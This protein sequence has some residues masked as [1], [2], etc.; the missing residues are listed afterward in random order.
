M[1]SKLRALL[2][3]SVLS[4]ASCRGW[5]LEDRTGCPRLLYFDIQN[6]GS[7]EAGT[8]V[9]VHAFPHQTGEPVREVSTTVRDIQ[10]HIFGVEVRSAQ[11]VEGY[12]LLGG[13]SL[14]QGADGYRLPAGKSYAPLFRFAYLT[15]VPEEYGVL[16][17]ELLKEYAGVRL[18]FVGERGPLA[19]TVRANTCGLR[20]DTGEPLQ[21]PF[22]CRLS[23]DDDGFYHF[24]LPRL[25][26]NRLTLEITGQNGLPETLDLFRILQEDGG[27]TWKERNLPD[28]GLVIDSVARTVEVRVSPWEWEDLSYEY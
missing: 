3:L 23:T 4:L 18:Q 10:S 19:V 21:G 1:S 2:L 25:T 15:S 12:A 11:P 14:V 7:F 13:E 26:D 9:R 22:E 17:V 8:K 28:V 6:A 24:N 5:V 16:P 20:P 27:I